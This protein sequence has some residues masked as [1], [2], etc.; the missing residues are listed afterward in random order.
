[1][2]VE[3]KS[4]PE[5]KKFIFRLLWLLVALVATI[6][7]FTDRFVAFGGDGKPF[8]LFFTAWSVWIAFAVAIWAFVLTVSSLKENKIFFTVKFAA[9]IMIIATFIVSAFVLPD[10]IWMKS[11]WTFGSTFKHFLLP[12]FTVLDSAF[13]DPA[14]SFKFWHPFAGVVAPVIYWTSVILRAVIHRNAQGGIIPS[15]EWNKYY[16]YGFTN[17]DNGHS[18]KG[19][20]LLLLGIGIGLLG[21]GYLIVLINSKRK[22][23]D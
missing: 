13:F 17:L 19:L 14:K 1:M 9:D 22:V 16:P 23:K 7:S 8:A 6:S 20:C 21:I 2:E 3:S 18:L 4:K 10:K 11:Y 12:I 15:A 5:T